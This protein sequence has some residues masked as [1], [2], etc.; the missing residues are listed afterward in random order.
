MLDILITNCTVVDGTG[1]APFKSD[2]GVAG[3]R[4][5]AVASEISLEA[6]RTIDAQGLHLAPGFIDPHSHS[7][8][9]LLV[10]RKA[11]SKIRQGVTTEIV[12]NCGSSGGPLY[13]AAETEARARADLLGL[14][15]T[16]AEFGG[17]LD[18]L[19]SPGTA[20]NV[21]PLVGHNTVRGAVL[22]YSDVQPD[23]DQLRAMEQLVDEA[24]DQGARGFST[25]LYYRPGHYAGTDEVVALARVAARRGGTYFTH[26][27]NESDKALA[28]LA[29]AIEVGQRA[30]IVIQIAHLKLSGHRNWEKVDA[31]VALLEDGLRAG[32]RVGADQ[33]P[34]TASSTGLASMLP[35]WAL[36]GGSKEIAA[37]MRDEQVRARLRREWEDDREGWENRAG[38]REWSDIV[39]SACDVRPEVLGLS[40]AEIA[41]AEGAD[42]LD[43]AFDLIAESEGMVGSIRHAQ[44]EDVVQ[45]LMQ[46]PIV[47]AGSDGYA[48][49]PDGVLGRS[50]PHPRSYGTF[51]RILGKYVR[52]E[53]VLTL[54]EAVRKMT[55]LPAERLGLSGRGVV[56]EGAWADLVLF[57]AGTVV[58]KATFA[59]PH[60]YPAGIPYVIVNGE[61]VVDGGEHTGALPGQVL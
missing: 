57:D 33:Y 24:M 35:Y 30:N 10:D 21:V 55:G 28:A 59:D 6:A 45:K 54:E 60:Q 23:P 29:E 19:R 38:M 37:R 31:L 58:D 52:D 9:T 16:W 5:A 3:G 34:Y 39:I 4:I 25:G 46:L 22:G 32:V 13:G 2:V 18:R 49:S 26:V 14:D 56:R 40:L 50:K 8:L 51:P 36:V 41:A 7:D 1:G 11:Q 20:V 53:G 44:S 48:L 17:F 61:V 12:G 47:V 27:R 15:V 42:P 43:V